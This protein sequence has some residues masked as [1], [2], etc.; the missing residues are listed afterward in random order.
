M[1]FLC[2]N[3]CKLRDNAWTLW[4]LM[5]LHICPVALSLS[6]GAWLNGSVFHPCPVPEHPVWSP[7]CSLIST[8]KSLSPLCI[9]WG[10]CWWG[11]ICLDHPIK[12]LAIGTIKRE[13]EME[14]NKEKRR[15]H[16]IGKE[17]YGGERAE[18]RKVGYKVRGGVKIERREE[19]NWESEIRREL[20][21]VRDC[22]RWKKRCMRL[23]E[24]AKVCSAIPIL[25]G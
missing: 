16:E 25:G 22:R 13:R 12:P 1:F 11:T 9:C 7:C 4:F 8:K 20:S 2:V 19:K 23:K 5:T 18:G 3:T 17:M 6:T 10:D 14:K 24:L 21:L 15:V